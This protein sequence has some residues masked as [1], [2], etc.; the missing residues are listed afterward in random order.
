MNTPKNPERR[1][2]ELQDGIV[3]K[4]RVSE[5]RILSNWSYGICRDGDLKFTS[6][7]FFPSDWISKDH[8]WIEAT[9]EDYASHSEQ[10]A[11]GHRMAEAA[12]EWCAAN[13]FPD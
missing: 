2:T 11:K 8:Y 9:D 1:V 5:S 6:G 10:V 12:G 4:A 3:Y 13:N 7:G